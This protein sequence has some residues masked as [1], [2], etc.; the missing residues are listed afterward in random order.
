MLFRFVPGCNKSRVTGRI[1]F[2]SIILA[3]SLGL[4]A[5]ILSKFHVRE[6]T[7]SYAKDSLESAE[8]ISLQVYICLFA[9]KMLRYKRGVLK[10]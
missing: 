1:H 2:V 5:K 8:T 6:I 4:D 9:D 3:I 10:L 7:T